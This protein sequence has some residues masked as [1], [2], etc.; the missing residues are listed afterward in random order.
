MEP[1]PAKVTVRVDVVRPAAGE[2]AEVQVRPGRD[3][4][5][6]RQRNL[7]PGPDHLANP[8]SNRGQVSEPRLDAGAAVDVDLVTA[9]HARR[10][11][12]RTG[13]AN[14]A[15]L[16]R[17]HRS[18]HRSRIV[19]TLVDPVI[20]LRLHHLLQRIHEPAV[21]VTG[22]RISQG[23]QVPHTSAAGLLLREHELAAVNNARGLVLGAV[24]RI[25]AVHEALG[26]R[27]TRQLIHAR[28]DSGNG[29]ERANQAIIDHRVHDEPNRRLR[30]I[31]DRVPDLLDRIDARLESIRNG[32]RD[33][34]AQEIEHRLDDVVPSPLDGVADPIERRLDD[35]LVEPP[36]GR[37]EDVLEEVHPRVDR[38]LDD[39]QPDPIDRRTDTV[40]NGFYD[41][42]TEP[43]EDCR[44]GYLED[45]N[46]CVNRRFDD[47]VPD[48][49]DGC[50][51][52]VE[53][54]D[55]HA[56][57]EPDHGLGQDRAEPQVPGVHNWFDHVVGHPLD[58]RTDAVEDGLDHAVA[59]PR[60]HGCE[61][62]TNETDG[63]VEDRYGAVPPVGNSRTDP[64]ED[65]DHDVVPPPYEQRREDV[66][67]D[68]D[69]HL[70]YAPEQQVEAAENNGCAVENRLEDVHPEPV[71]DIVRRT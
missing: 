61:D 36:H 18:A 67:D 59:E 63:T 66:L 41:A 14:P 56:V 16:R 34:R 7:L 19:D 28:Q 13:P 47:V 11:N 12:T 48:P 10:R 53:D 8:H 23:I 54:R 39:V 70:E 55:Y 25:T 37:R 24:A 20:T 2:R 49:L 44:Q 69:D 27:H 57:S 68:R 3:A 50:T 1:G 60:K 35:R 71:E 62:V 65:R 58:R 38:G 17:E 26:Q 15:V 5:V 43:R 9:P 4:R 32:F 40:K 45:V 52:P 64:L 6:A 22:Q 46:P 51:D 33:R 29:V 31:E 30:D 21:H 42:V